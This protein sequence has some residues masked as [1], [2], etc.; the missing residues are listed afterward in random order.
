MAN[1]RTAEVRDIISLLG[2]V[3]AE[4]EAHPGHPLWYRGCKLASYDLNP[5]LYRHPDSAAHGGT[6]QL[7]RAILDRFKQRSVPYLQRPMENDWEW[8]FYMQHYGVPTRLLDWTESPLV[9]AY[10]AVKDCK[11]EQDAP[12]AIWVLDPL[13][14]DATA[15][16]E[17]K[18]DGSPLYPDEDTQSYYLPS[19]RPAQYP[20]AVY[21]THNSARIVAQQ[22]VFTVFGSSEEPMN[23]LVEQGVFPESSILKITIPADSISRVAG[24]LAALAF[25]ESVVYPDLE[26]LAAEF[27]ASFGFGD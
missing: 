7:E 6:A 14:W 16:G 18:I 9:A 3:N 15:L 24:D 17:I 12:S 26:G 27:K 8:L 21:G 23:R 20:L 11:A 1:L 2:I 10:F 4:L 22:G 5:S 25:T 13:E 19:K